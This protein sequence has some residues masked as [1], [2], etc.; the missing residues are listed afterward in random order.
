MLT[1]PGHRIFR[2]RAQRVSTMHLY[3]LGQP[4]KLR[5]GLGG[6]NLSAEIYRVTGKLPVSND[7]PQYRIR[8][9]EEP[10]ER[11]AAQDQLEPITDTTTDPNATLI[12]KTFGFNG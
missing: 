5:N 11:M 7:L 3:D 2:D 6:K 1:K 12:E 4:V 8:S 9:D 10:Y